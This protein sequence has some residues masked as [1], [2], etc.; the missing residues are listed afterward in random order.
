VAEEM[1]VPVLRE[2]IEAGAYGVFA[3]P[4]ERLELAEAV[5]RTR[6][7]RSEDP[8]T[9]GRVVAVYGARGGA[10]ATFLL[11]HLAAA[12]AGRGERT[13]VA[14]LDA[15]FADLTVALG[16][17]GEEA[18]TIADLVDVADELAP[19]H[20][21]EVLYAHP[22]GFSALLGPGHHD[23]IT[24]IPPGLYPGC[25]ALLAGS[26]DIVLVL[27]PRALD[28]LAQAAVRMADDVLLVVTLDLFALFGAR[29]ALA[30]LQMD[31]PPGRCRVVV[32]RAA[33]SDV[34]AG[35]VERILGIRPSAVVR[36]DPAVRRAQDRGELLPTRA[37][38]VGRDIDALARALLAAR[39]RSAQ[40][41]A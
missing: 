16:V 26:F 28:T 41:T 30:A 9:R 12:M 10:G 13:V 17:S 1:T 29:R 37:G 5:A 23:N 39:E 34:T 7:S 36:F 2:A 14:D 25:I 31:D 33:R 40:G 6:R 11:S 18:R 21:E 32:N 35:D 27:V 4:E 8:E 3:W 15:E 24:S 38:R 20:L 22:R 19:D